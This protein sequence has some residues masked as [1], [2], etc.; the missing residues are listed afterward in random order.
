[1]YMHVCVC[2]YVCVCECMLRMY[3]CT[4]VFIYF[5]NLLEITEGKSFLHKDIRKERGDVY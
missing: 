3:V 1:M 4:Y 2:M 5:L